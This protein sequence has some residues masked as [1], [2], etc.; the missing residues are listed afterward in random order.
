MIKTIESVNRPFLLFFF[1]FFSSTSRKMLNVGFFYPPSER[2]GDITISLASVHPSID[3]F[4][5]FALNDFRS[6]SYARHKF[7]MCRNILIIFN[8]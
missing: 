7:H 6:V 3:T 4:L 2:F 5:L 8:R 1:F